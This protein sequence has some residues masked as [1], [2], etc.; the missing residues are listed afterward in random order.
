MQIGTSQKCN[1]PENP[2]SLHVC[3]QKS[4]SI[5]LLMLQRTV[6]LML[7][8]TSNRHH[9]KMSGKEGGQQQCADSNKTH[10]CDADHDLSEPRQV[11]WLLVL[12]DEAW[13]RSRNLALR[14]LTPQTSDVI[15]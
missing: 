15:I 12:L 11:E 9:S 6:A 7:T 13:V 1:H 3:I 2:D 14:R 5:P 8:S 4:L 10:D